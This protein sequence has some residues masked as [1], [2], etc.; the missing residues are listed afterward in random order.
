[1]RAASWW[2]G[3]RAARHRYLRPSDRRPL[4]SRRKRF[5]WRQSSGRRSTRSWSWRVKFVNQ[6]LYIVDVDDRLEDPPTHRCTQRWPPRAREAVNQNHG[7]NPDLLTGT[8]EREGCCRAASLRLP[9]RGTEE[10]HRE[11]R[12]I[13]RGAGIS[14]MQGRS[15]NATIELTISGQDRCHFATLI[16]TTHLRST[17]L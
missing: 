6:I 2:N 7:G 14:W 10:R 13:C 9:G 15:A 16:T 17:F 11:H 3:S 4:R 8:G 1:M 12:C 5:R